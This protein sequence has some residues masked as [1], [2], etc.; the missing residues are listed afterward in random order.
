MP[1]STLSRGNVLYDTMLQAT[2]TPPATITTGTQTQTTT[3]I[4]GLLVGDLISWNQTSFTNA[5]VSVTNMYVSAPGVLTSNWTTEGT[6]Q[7]GVAAQT[8]LIEVLRYENI[9]QG[10]AT[11]PTQLL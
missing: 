11:L 1:A 3:T 8:F 2:I 10:I 9:S 7:T 4:V 5:L 6:T